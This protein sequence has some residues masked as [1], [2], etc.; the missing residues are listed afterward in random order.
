MGRRPYKEKYHTSEGAVMT[1]EGGGVTPVSEIEDI[2]DRVATGK[3]CRRSNGTRRS[4]GSVYSRL[5]QDGC[6]TPAESCSIHRVMRGIPME[7]KGVMRNAQL[8]LAFEDALDGRDRANAAVLSP[9]FDEVRGAH[10]AWAVC[11]RQARG[12]DA[13]GFAYQLKMNGVTKERSQF[14]GSSSR[15]YSEKE[16]ALLDQ[17]RQG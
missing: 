6:D 8:F 16:G 5:N 13:E 12:D 10:M 17:R 9:R 7:E 14:M 2:G 3:S 15:N 4:R 11:L 1:E